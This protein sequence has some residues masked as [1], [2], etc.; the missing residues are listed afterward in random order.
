ML[1]T[2]N[3]TYQENI[4]LVKVH[5]ST[6]AIDLDGPNS[7][8]SVFIFCFLRGGTLFPACSIQQREAQFEI[9]QWQVA[10]TKWIYFW[11][12]GWVDRWVG[13]GWTNLSFLLAHWGF[14]SVTTSRCLLSCLFT[15][16]LTQ[17]QLPSA[18]RKYSQYSQVRDAKDWC[19]FPPFL[20]QFNH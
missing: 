10:F 6:A 4:R 11:T 3:Q 16:G 8:A 19:Y 17:V 9:L 20:L 5:C 12:A 18:S 14:W 1:Y 13:M 15:R 7:F 2:H